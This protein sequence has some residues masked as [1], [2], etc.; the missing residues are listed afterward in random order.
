MKTWLRRSI[1]LL[2]VLFVFLTLPLPISAVEPPDE[3]QGT[4]EEE[5]R[6]WVFLMELTDNPVAAAGI[7]G[8]LFYESHLSPRNL[9][10]M[11]KKAPEFENGQDYG[12]ATD[13][14]TYEKFTTDGFGYGLA[15]WTYSGR[16]RRLLE[17]AREQKKSVSDLDVQLTL[18]AEELEKY[19]MLYRISHADRISFVS[20]YFLEHFENPQEQG[21]KERKRR[22]KRAR[23]YYDKFHHELKADG[24]TQAQ[25][26]VAKIA[27]YSSAY[28]VEAEEG[29]CQAWASGVVSAAGFAHDVSPSA[30][31]SAEAYKVSDD[32]TTIPVGAAIYGHSSSKYGH[33]GIYVGN[34]QVYHNIGGVQVDTL[35]D[36]IVNYRGFCWGWIGGTDLTKVKDKEEK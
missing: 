27:A 6:I 1:S 2:L 24:L 23:Y 5:M 36:W 7:M 10:T 16:K 33:V 21:Y 19:H 34:N 11:G 12:S 9:E 3:V 18:I 28:G 17:I 31:A 20:S 22:A 4:A 26:D 30:E 29:L 25:K 8:N 14:G 35:E 32:L 15:Q 13:D